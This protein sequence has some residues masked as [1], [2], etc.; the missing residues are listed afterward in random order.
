MR[1]SGLWTDDGTWK[2]MSGK[3]VHCD[4]DWTGLNCDDLTA[5][6]LH[7][8]IDYRREHLC[9]LGRITRPHRITGTQLRSARDLHLT[10]L[11]EECDRD[12][13]GEPLEG[14]V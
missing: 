8:R 4:S 1:L 3:F 6:I 10:A 5:E 9:R 11:Q 13:F 14:R 12:D 7:Y 2:P